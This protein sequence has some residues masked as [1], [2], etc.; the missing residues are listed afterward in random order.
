MKRNGT[1]GQ[2]QLGQ[3]QQA[4]KWWRRDRSLT[5]FTFLEEKGNTSDYKS[6]LGKIFLALITMT[7]PTI[8]PCLTLPKKGWEDQVDDEM[9]NPMI[10]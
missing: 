3:S 5:K 8:M 7:E 9:G 10:I 2:I 4:D 6:G 1:S